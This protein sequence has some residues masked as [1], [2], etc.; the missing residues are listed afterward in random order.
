MQRSKALHGRGSVYYQRLHCHTLF[1]RHVSQEHWCCPQRLRSQ[2]CFSPPPPLALSPFFVC[3][4]SSSSSST[5]HD[6]VPIQLLGS[7][8][9]G[10]SCREPRST[11]QTGHGFWG[12][13]FFNLDFRWLLGVDLVWFVLNCW[14]NARICGLIVVGLCLYLVV[15]DGGWFGFCIPFK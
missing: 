9:F 5:A 15:V 3:C 2:W 1:L 6:E 8:V 11:S 12:F 4:F 7:W 13:Y 14:I 10:Y